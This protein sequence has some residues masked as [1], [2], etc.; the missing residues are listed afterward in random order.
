MLSS[1]YIRCSCATLSATLISTSLFRLI[2]F[3]VSSVCDV[4]TMNKRN[5]LCRFEQ[6]STTLVAFRN[7]HTNQPTK[8]AAAAMSVNETYYHHEDKYANT[9]TNTTKVV[10]PISTSCNYVMMMMLMMMMI[11]VRSHC[12]SVCLC[13]WCTS[14]GCVT[15]ILCPPPRVHISYY[16]PPRVCACVCVMY[17]LGYNFPLSD[18]RF[19]ILFFLLE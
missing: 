18:L 19:Y 10:A 9:Q 8:Q 1:T 2:S 6:H 12:S 16:P 17:A 15:I 13:L 4:L 5:Y 14:V 11:Y 7:H 3:C